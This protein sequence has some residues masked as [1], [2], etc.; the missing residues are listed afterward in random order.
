M[1][2]EVLGDSEFRAEVGLWVSAQGS[3]QLW[4]FLCLYCQ[5]LSAPFLA[6]LPCPWLSILPIQ[7]WRE[8]S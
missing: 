1:V 5:P 8:T 7:E 4:L 2:K 3:P 6:H